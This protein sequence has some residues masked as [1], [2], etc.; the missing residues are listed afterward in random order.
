MLPRS[1]AF[2]V[3]AVGPCMAMAVVSA[4]SSDDVLAQP[5]VNPGVDDAT[6][7]QEL[8]PKVAQDGGDPCALPEGTTCSFGSTCGPYAQCLR[9]VWVYGSTPGAPPCSDTPPIADA[10]CPPCWPE[11]VVCRYGSEDCSQAD[12]SAN[13]TFATCVEGR[14]TLTYSPCADA[15]TDVQGDGGADRD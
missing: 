8:C 9:G 4:C 12:A 11:P 14:W 6:V 3:L 10:S 7:T 5:G 2:V 1:T 13:R 15:S